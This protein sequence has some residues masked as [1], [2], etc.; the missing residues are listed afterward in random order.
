MRG[1]CLTD[2]LR[3][4]GAG[5]L[6]KKEVRGP[7]PTSCAGREARRRSTGGNTLALLRS[8][9]RKP[10]LLAVQRAPHSACFFRG[11]VLMIRA[12]NSSAACLISG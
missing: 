6:G 5:K 4:V 11:C 9:D 10:L 2:I 7:D 1:T 12:P 8:E 3:S